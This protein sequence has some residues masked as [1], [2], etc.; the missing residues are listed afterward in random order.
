[1]KRTLRLLGSTL[2]MMT[3]L[4]APAA[5]SA[6]PASQSASQSASDRLVT[7]GVSGGVSLPN[8]DYTEGLESGYTL[9]GHLYLKP[10][11]FTS[12][13]FRGDVSFDKWNAEA[14]NAGSFR[15]L[16]FVVNA[17]YEFPTASTSIVRPYLLGGLGAFNTEA[18]DAD[19]DS[20]TNLG[21]QV[22]GGLNFALS[23][24]TTFAEAKFVN[25]FTDGS[26]LRYIPITF[27][28]R[29]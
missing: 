4:A 15:S 18:S 20:D 12:L 2:G 3:V 11:T 28:V 19:S 9:A 26:S 5:L 24:F 17:M 10:G 25:V 21:L 8:G 13:R 16:G 14:E 27:G 29:F 1:M 22:G 7:L 23:G 6:Q